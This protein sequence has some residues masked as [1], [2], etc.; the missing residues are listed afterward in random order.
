M[1]GIDTAIASALTSRVDSLLGIQP[2][3][4][5]T[6][7]T[8]ATGVGN[9]PN[10]AP[11]AATPAPQPSAQTALSA[12]ALTLDAIARSGG[13]V[14][15]A[16][17]GQTPIW[18]AAPALDVEVEGLPLFDTQAAATTSGAT[19]NT[20][21]TANVAAAQVPVAALAAAL[22]QTVSDSGLFYEAHLA[23]WL[24]GQRSPDSLAD[25]AQNKL[26]AAAAQLPLDW[27]ADEGD[28][29]A[30][31]TTSRQ[32][33]GAAPNGS[34]NGSPDANTASRAT[35]SILTA[36]AARFAAGEVLANSLS[37]LSNQP[38]HAG[39]HSA[40]AAATDTDSSPGSQQ[41][42]AAVH[43]AT[44]PLVRQQLDLLATG[45]FRWTGEAWPGARLDW[46]IEQDGDEWDRRARTISRGAHV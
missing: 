5:A 12:V 43:P 33:M 26:V 35:Q 36:Q 22:E 4:A 37:E 28:E 18:P 8:G 32:G 16:V 2:G 3:S 25:E 14:T 45:Q 1:N 34:P 39:L 29:S 30:P 23:Q 11:P 41:A 7:Q 19:S 31:N 38:A 40:T 17:L 15:L 13:E 21:A 27:S 44:V 10:T 9:A 24:A 20:T 46:T 42:T 6:S